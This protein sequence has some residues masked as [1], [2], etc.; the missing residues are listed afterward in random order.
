MRHSEV[1]FSTNTPNSISDTFFNTSLSGVTIQATIKHETSGPVA[2]EVVIHASNDGTDFFKLAT[3]E[4]IG[5]T[6]DSDGICNNPSWPFY[7]AEVSNLT[8]FSHVNVTI[9]TFL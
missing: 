8:G 3:L 4:L 5:T 1:I 9:G 2:S 7:R 6:S